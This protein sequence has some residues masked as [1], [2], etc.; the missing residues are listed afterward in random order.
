MT[1]SVIGILFFLAGAFNILASNVS[2]FG[3]VAFLMLAG[4]AWAFW[5]N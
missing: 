1:L 3:G 5:R 4:L 2:T